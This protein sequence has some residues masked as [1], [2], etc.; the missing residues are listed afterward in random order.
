[1]VAWRSYRLSF[2]RPEVLLLIFLLKIVTV[3]VRFA[4]SLTED[5]V[6]LIFFFISNYGWKCIEVLPTCYE[7][8]LDHLLSN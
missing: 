1:M 7:N 2:K 3:G 5:V 8:D 4:A 6:E